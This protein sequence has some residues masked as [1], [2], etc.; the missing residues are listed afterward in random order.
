M[1]R[2]KII[3]FGETLIDLTS[4]TVTPETLLKGQTAHDKAGN[5]IVGTYDPKP[6]TADFNATT[7]WT[8]SGTTYTVTV[9]ASTHGRGTTPSVDVYELNNSAYVKYYGFPSSGWTVSVDSSGNVKITVPNSGARF[10]GR[11]QIW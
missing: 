7:D 4:D 2:N 1:G 11:L 6:Y 8:S 3:Y 10:A 9:A 5:I